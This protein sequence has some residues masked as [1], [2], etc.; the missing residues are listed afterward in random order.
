M[1]IF[2]M[3]DEEYF[4]LDKLSRSDIAMID[5]SMNHYLS[6]KN[7]PKHDTPAMMFGR[8]SHAYILEGKELFVLEEERNP[9]R[10]TKDYKEWKAFQTLDILSQDDFDTLKKMKKNFDSHVKIKEMFSDTFY[11]EHVITFDHD[12]VEC[13]TKLDRFAVYKNKIIAA[14]LKTTASL[15]LHKLSNSI[16]EYKYYIQDPFYSLSLSNEFNFPLEKIEFYF[17]FIEKTSPYD[18]RV[19]RL[20]D[21]YRK[22]G[23]GIIE[24]ALS[25]FKSGKYEGYPQ[26]IETLEKPTWLE[27]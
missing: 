15:D 4:A 3:S 27:I 9:N 21:E 25:K 1:S 11:D 7:Q 6:Y 14:D 5:V 13:K 20:D 16:L 8:I 10:K 18:I 23:L 12:D 19:I 22:Y 24:L 17:I 2:Q 26:V